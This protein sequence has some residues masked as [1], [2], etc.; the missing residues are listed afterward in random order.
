MPNTMETSRQDLLCSWGSVVLDRWA[1]S[2]AR[3]LLLSV[4]SFPFKSVVISLQKTILTVNITLLYIDFYLQ[5][6]A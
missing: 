4:V 5:E 1:G 6:V 2:Q 3:G